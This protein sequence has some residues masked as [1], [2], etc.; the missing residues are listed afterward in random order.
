M[1][2]DCEFF[3]KTAI[4]RILYRKEDIFRTII[5]TIANLVLKI[6]IIF[7]QTPLDLE[8]ED[9]ISLSADW[10]EVGVLKTV[11]IFKSIPEDP[12]KR[13]VTKQYQSGKLKRDYRKIDTCYIAGD[14]E[15]FMMEEIIR[16]R[17]YGRVNRVTNKADIRSQKP[18]PKIPSG[19][20]E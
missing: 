7:P 9:L 14:C 16:K 3:N 18:R 10:P 11:R 5:G 1:S 6:L 13:T 2:F 17:P 12:V 15:A 4:F 20:G 19:I 8:L